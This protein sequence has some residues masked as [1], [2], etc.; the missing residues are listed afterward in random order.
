MAFFLVAELSDKKQESAGLS[1]MRRSFLNHSNDAIRYLLLYIRIHTLTLILVD[2]D[3][4][5]LAWPDSLLE[6]V[7]SNV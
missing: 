3:Q 1:C 2:K 5:I 7:A 4:D 6:T